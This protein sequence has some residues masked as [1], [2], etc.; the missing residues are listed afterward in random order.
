MK[1]LKLFDELYNT[2]VPDKNFSRRDAMSKGLSFGL[3]AA[4]AAIPLGLFET[5]GNKAYATPPPTTSVVD[6][7]HTLTPSPCNVFN[8]F[9]PCSRSNAV[10]IPGS[11]AAP[12]TGQAGHAATLCA[13]YPWEP[14]RVYRDDA[15]GPSWQ[16]QYM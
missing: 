15:R 5:I 6:V 12:G 9:K 1:A 14:I 3:K 4:L 7:L 13:A 8:N 10:V 11:T 16:P 2:E